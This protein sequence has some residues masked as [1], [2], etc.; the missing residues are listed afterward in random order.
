MAPIKRRALTNEERISVLAE[1]EANPSLNSIRSLAT[2]YN[3]SKGQI[4][5]VIKR[6]EEIKEASSKNLD[7]KRKRMTL[8]KTTT[9]EEVN[10]LTLQFIS[11]AKGNDIHISGTLIKEKA[12]DYAKRLGYNNFKASDG[13]LDSF[14]K[15]NNI[16][17]KRISGEA[18]NVDKK[19]VPEFKESLFALLT[20]LSDAG[21]EED[22]TV[23]V[24]D[25][26]ST[27]ITSAQF[28][29]N[30]KDMKNYALEKNLDLLDCIEELEKQFSSSLISSLTQ[31]QFTDIWST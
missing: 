5:N 28:R 4:V 1:R 21:E 30:L 2:K 9:Y 27:I 29:S 14:K 8:T 20:D 11:A 31:K 26:T 19:I 7:P 22:T 16:K 15:R 25:E 24:N 3:V 6:R 17:T 12:L 23:V 10:S 18:S 13:W